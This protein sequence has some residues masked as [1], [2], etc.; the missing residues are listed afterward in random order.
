MKM[1]DLHPAQFYR[2]E[3]NGVIECELCPHNCKISNNKIGICKVRKNIEGKLYSLNYGQVSSLGIDPVEKK[4]LYHFYPQS[5]VLSLGSWGCNMSCEFCQNWQISQ[6][7]PSLREFKPAEIVESALEKNVNLIAYTYSEPTVFYEYMLETA[8]IA[9]E[10]G[11]K[12]I[13]VSNGYINQKPLENLIPFID[14]ANIDLKAFNNQFYLKHCNGGLEAVK[15]TIK[16]LAEKIHLEV[17]TLIVT[18]LNDDLDELEKLFRWLS[19][20]N[21]EIP[22][23]L[24]RYYPA[25]KLNNPPT[26]LQ[27]MKSSYQLAKKNIWTMFIWVMRL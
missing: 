5:E 10:R 15:R 11:L 26:D 9:A 21:S 1:T 3:D 4:P 6:Q 23:H 25:Y 27:V 12:N 20:I 16:I 2:L 13:L 24:I 7:K 18:D 14:A 22:L 19:E 17:T 8:E